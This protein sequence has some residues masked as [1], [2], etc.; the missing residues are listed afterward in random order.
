MNNHQRVLAGWRRLHYFRDVEMFS[1]AEEPSLPVGPFRLDYKLARG[2]ER[3]VGSARLV[4]WFKEHPNETLTPATVRRLSR[5]VDSSEYGDLFERLLSSGQR[6]ETGSGM[7]QV[8]TRLSSGT[9][10]E[11]AIFLLKSRPY[12]SNPFI[13]QYS[14]DMRVATIKRLTE[15]TYSTEALHYLDLYKQT[16]CQDS[17]NLNTYYRLFNDLLLQ[18]GRQPELTRE[19]IHSSIDLI[20]RYYFLVEKDLEKGLK[21]MNRYFD[22]PN[23]QISATTI[24]LINKYFL[25]CLS[26]T[27]GVDPVVVLGYLTTMYPFSYRFLETS[28]LLNMVY[29]YRVQPVF[30]PEKQLLRP[31][32]REELVDP[33]FPVSLDMLAFAY[34]SY[35]YGRRPG[36]IKTRL[37]FEKYLALSQTDLHTDAFA[38]TAVLE[39]FLGYVVNVLQLPR[40][41]A[42]FLQLFCDHNGFAK[43]SRVHSTGVNN[44]LVRLAPLDLARA[45]SLA[46]QLAKVVS[47]NNRVY[48]TFIHQ[49]VRLGD[50]ETAA[51]FYRKLLELQ[52]LHPANSTYLG[53]RNLAEMCSKFNWPPPVIKPHVEHSPVIAERP[54]VNYLEIVRLLDS[55]RPG[56]FVN[57]ELDTTPF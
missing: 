55:M 25:K 15:K 36:K 9:A 46:K 54:K 40:F 5:A 23:V 38:S 53:Q 56:S 22:I 6:F 13:S 31:N 26:H 57:D 49:L 24:S 32:I 41:A 28:G 1:G 2:I 45:I 20:L 43:A 3:G 47:L 44:L 8:I 51:V 17:P 18:H 21:I 48:Y 10:R 16:L 4:S 19:N 33:L 39:T 35:L 52:S 30:S 14:D 50:T 37:L 27:P 34:H 29:N 11:K 12:D 7:S 42:R